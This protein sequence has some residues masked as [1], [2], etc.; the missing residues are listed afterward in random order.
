VNLQNI[1][2]LNLTVADFEATVDWYGR[3]FGF[4]LVEEDVQEGIRWGVIRQ[5]DVMLCI[6][7]YPGCRFE[8]RFAMRRLGLHGINH[9]GLRITD[10]GEWEETMDREGVEVLY[11]G[12]VRW[13]HSTSW[14][15]T[16]PTGWEIEV[17]LWDDDTIRF[18]GR[19]PI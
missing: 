18:A 2:H 10:R 8:D 13:P 16:D 4:E 5:G 12:P 19:T 11:G 3:V 17:A 15:V 6:Y 1:D 9:F 14:Y 7:Q